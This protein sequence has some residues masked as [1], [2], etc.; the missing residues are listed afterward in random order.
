MESALTERHLDG[1][2]LQACGGSRCQ[3]LP[4]IVPEPN[5]AGGQEPQGAETLL[6]AVPT[7]LKMTPSIKQDTK[8]ITTD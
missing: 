2:L 6:A 3:A 5:R 1:V 8:F 7:T 4:V